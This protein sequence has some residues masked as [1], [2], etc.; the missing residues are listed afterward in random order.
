MVFLSLQAA[1]AQS[2]KTMIQAR[3]LRTR[4]TKLSRADQF[5]L[6]NLRYTLR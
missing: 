3:F 4:V 5:L 6:Q 1:E 2:D